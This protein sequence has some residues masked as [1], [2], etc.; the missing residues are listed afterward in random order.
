MAM[1]RGPPPVPG[2]LRAPGLGLM[3]AE[4][5]GIFEFNTSLLLSPLLLLMVLQL[6]T[7]AHATDTANVILEFM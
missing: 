6:T 5:R 2:K 1:D 7:Q 4:V 3:L